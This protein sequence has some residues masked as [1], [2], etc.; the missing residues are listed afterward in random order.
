MKKNELVSHVMSNNIISVQQGQSLSEVRH[1]MVDSNIH[2]IPVLSGQ[3]LIGMISFTDMMK[4]NVVINGADDRTIDSII[5]QQFEIRDIMNRDLTVLDTKDT[6]RQAANLLAENNF[7][8]IPV[9][10]N[11]G[12]LEG[13]V[14]SSDLIRYLSDQY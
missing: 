2:H 6:I 5:D 1:K 3:K 8:A 14:T 11:S 4:L 13:I 12:D 10:N 9:T 7:H